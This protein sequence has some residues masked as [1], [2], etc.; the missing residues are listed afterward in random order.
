[1]SARTEGPDDLH[2]LVDELR[3]RF[4]LGSRNRPA[5]RAVLGI[6]GPPGAGKSTLAEA[7]VA[8]IGPAS[9]LV[10]M[11][12][13]H[14]PQRSLEDLGRADR[15]GAPDTFDVAAFVAMLARLREPG[16]NVHAPSFDRTI[17][18][19][20]ADAI[21][22]GAQVELVVTEGNYLLVD[23]GGWADVRVHLDACWYVAVPDE[24]RLARLTSRH[25][26]FGRT[27]LAAAEWARGTDERNAA[28]VRATRSRADRIVTLA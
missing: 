17:D 2:A 8:E 6:A 15:K 12:G 16:T 14:L 3:A 11:D 18:E 9:V 1:M 21:E 28:V 25:E 4:A 24:I 22:I 23:E 7:L 19:P 13:F 10:P 27:P 26:R 20:V 5:R